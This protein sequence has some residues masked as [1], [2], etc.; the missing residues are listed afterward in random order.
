[1]GTPR[2]WVARRPTGAASPGAFSLWSHFETTPLESALSQ[3]VIQWGLSLL[4]RPGFPKKIL[5]GTAEW[6]QGMIRRRPGCCPLDNV[7]FAKAI[8]E[9]A[10]MGYAKPW[11]STK[12]DVVEEGNVAPPDTVGGI[13]PV[14]VP[15]SCIVFVNHFLLSMHSTTFFRPGKTRLRSGQANQTR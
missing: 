7:P 8:L 10:T 14:E 5:C 11:A 12:L 13:L 4:P 2:L 15:A 6:A 3:S 1:M 9:P